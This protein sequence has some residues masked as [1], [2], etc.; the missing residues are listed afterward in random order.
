VRAPAGPPDASKAI[1]ETRAVYFRGGYRETPIYDRRDLQAGH[2][3]QGPAVVEAVDT[4]V[5]VHPGQG[6]AIDEYGNLLM[7]V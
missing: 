2:A 7:S 6:L 1:K 3:L 5:L 4:T